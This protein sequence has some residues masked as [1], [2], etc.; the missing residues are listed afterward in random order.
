MKQGIWTDRVWQ[1]KIVLSKRLP[2][3]VRMKNCTNVGVTQCNVA[4]NSSIHFLCWHASR[5]DDS[6][7][8][9]HRA[10]FPAFARTRPLLASTLC[11]FGRGLPPRSCPS[12]MCQV[13]GA[14]RVTFRMM[15]VN[16][17][18]VTRHRRVAILV[19]VLWGDGDIEVVLTYSSVFIGPEIPICGCPQVCTADSMLLKNKFVANDITAATR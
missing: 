19:T 16:M 3:R 7:N 11:C 1:T 12:L 5:K 10:A 9:H 15:G 18:R 14:S 4:I 8:S 17:C 13:I 6:I 2:L